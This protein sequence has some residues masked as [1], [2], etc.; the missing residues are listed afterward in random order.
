MNPSKLLL[1][2]GILKSTADNPGIM[3]EGVI[4]I[5]AFNFIK[6]CG[7]EQLVAKV[8][9]NVS[10]LEI[11][12]NPKIAY[13]AQMSMSL[14]TPVKVK[15]TAKWVNDAVRI[16][17]EEFE[18]LRKPV[19]N[20]NNIKIM[21]RPKETDYCNETGIS[22]F[23]IEGNGVHSAHL[24][25]NKQ[26]YIP[27]SSSVMQNPSFAQYPPRLN[28]KESQVLQS[29]GPKMQ[30]NFPAFSNFDLQT[31]KS[32]PIFVPNLNIPQLIQQPI[33]QQSKIPSQFPNQNYLNNQNQLIFHDAVRLSQYDP[34][35]FGLKEQ[36]QPISYDFQSLP[37]CQPRV[38]PQMTQQ[39]SPVTSHQGNPFITK[40]EHLFAGDRGWKIRGRIVTKQE[41][42]KFKNDRGL[43]FSIVLEDMG[44]R[45]RATFFNSAAMTYYE[46][47]HENSIYL[48]S[49]GNVEKASKYNTTDHRFEI[50][51]KDH[52]N[53]ELLQE[54]MSLSPKD[55]NE[56]FTVA[57]AQKR[58]QNELINMVLFIQD[59]G[60]FGL[61]ELKRGGQKALKQPIAI[62]KNGEIIEISLWGEFA[63]EVVLLSGHAYMIRSIKIKKFEEHTFLV[64]ENYTRI[65]SEVSP[66]HWVEKIIPSQ[67]S[68]QSDFNYVRQPV[69]ALENITFPLKDNAVY[70]CPTLPNSDPE[71]SADIGPTRMRDHTLFT[72]SEINKRCEEFFSNPYNKYKKLVLEGYGFLSHI[73]KNIWYD[74]C[75]YKNC[76][77]KIKDAPKEAK[78]CEKCRMAVPNT[79]TRFMADVKITDGNDCLYGR[80]FGEDNCVFMFG[81]DVDH[82]KNIRQLNEEEYYRI[83]RSAECN[84]F[85]FQILVRKSE[86][87]GENRIAVE[88]LQVQKLESVIDRLVPLMIDK[89]GQ[90]IVSF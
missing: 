79:I 45:I 59:E 18:I 28:Q 46:K 32:E 82:V 67:F 69:E 8:S 78:Y 50:I 48:M 12:I 19:A 42:K 35:K 27:V 39:F 34:N 10:S 64:W 57:D 47:L 52:A 65:V 49:E 72:L 68:K 6:I 5:L 63:K 11:I 20:E 37:S 55:Y 86:Y 76:K 33:F 23:K 4:Q 17:C 66:E 74:S 36:I 40:I 75:G 9:D 43:Y 13:N 1:T 16:I 38:F 7:N 41:M 22:N 54:N 80:I 15:L 83:V 88:F 24:A 87:Q 29:I 60:E 73:S 44:C 61:K 26:V 21:Q 81:M 84:E 58:N 71:I 53:V 30:Q 14:F 25:E 85:Y 3:S 56:F 89:L 70:T 31:Y 77:K 51:F 2:P 62:D 90:K